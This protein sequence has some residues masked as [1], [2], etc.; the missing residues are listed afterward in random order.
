MDV[1]QGLSV[2]RD[3]GAS[4]I[5]SKNKTQVAL[6]L[7]AG[8]QLIHVHGSMNNTLFCIEKGAAP[9]NSCL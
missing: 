2:S 5:K 1:K 3:L 9:Q 7:E 8:L 4:V 6:D